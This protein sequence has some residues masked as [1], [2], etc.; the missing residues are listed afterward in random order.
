MSKAVKGRKLSY[1]FGLLC[2]DGS[3]YKSIETVKIKG[4]SKVYIYSATMYNFALKT[5]D[6]ELINLFVEYFSDVF[7]RKKVTIHK[8]NGYY[9]T[10][11]RVSKEVYN[12]F[13]N[14][15]HPIIQKYPEDFIRGFADSEGSV[16]VSNHV[17]IRLCNTNLELLELVSSLLSKLGIHHHIRLQSKK[18]SP[19]KDGTRKNKDVYMIEIDRKE[20]VNKFADRINFALSSKKDK[21]N[22][23]LRKWNSIIISRDKYG[24]FIRVR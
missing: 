1:L 20:D 10:R 14:T 5:K 4:R 17:A 3:L 13:K 18:G 23:A 7:S 24:R 2:G 22:N 19:A 15:N 16:I 12:L 8:Y 21:L 6:K 11:F 9:Q